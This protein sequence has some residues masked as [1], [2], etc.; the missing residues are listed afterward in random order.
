M[1]QES[2]PK[3]EAALFAALGDETRLR[4]VS[5]LSQSGPASLSRLREGSNV[6]R[7][8]ISK[9]L[10]VMER[11]GLARSRRHGRETIW[12]LDP[13]KLSEV[14]Q[15]LESVSKHWDEA[16]ARLQRMVEG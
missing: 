8:A 15:Y 4:I 13:A 1:S 6:S 3:R 5:Q 16:L 11:S 9:H 14:K 2:E 10:R 12:Q 7:Q